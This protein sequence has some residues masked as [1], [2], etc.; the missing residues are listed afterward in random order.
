[1]QSSQ[2]HTASYYAATANE[3]TAYP[4]LAGD[5]DCDVCIIGGG[6]SGI[7]TA[8]FLADRGAK[9]VLL[10]SNRIGWGASGG[11]AG[12]STAGCRAKHASARRFAE[13]ATS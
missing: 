8:I 12:R 1:M 3:R 9:V 11:M 10:E 7:S 5:H 2:E 13:R 4:A 6:F